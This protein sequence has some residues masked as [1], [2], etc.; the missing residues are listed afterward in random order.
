MTADELAGMMQLPPCAR[1]EYQHDD[2][3]SF[4][5]HRNG[6]EAENY[7]TLFTAEQMHTYAL[8]HKVFERDKWAKVLAESCDDFRSDMMG[9]AG[10]SGGCS[11]AVA[12]ESDLAMLRAAFAAVVEA[13]AK[14]KPVMYDSAPAPEYAAF[15]GALDTARGL[16]RPNARL[17][18]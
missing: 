5:T 15:C 8:A 11:R 6:V 7:R 13:L 9:G 4:A 17:S 14:A 1:V 12:A 18:G 16:A 3:W 2:G 10:S